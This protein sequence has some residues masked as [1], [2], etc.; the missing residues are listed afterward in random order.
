MPDVA[1]LHHNLGTCSAGWRSSSKPSPHTSRHCGSIP[2]SPFRTLIWG[3]YCGAKGR[4]AHALP[5]MKQAVEFEPA[6]ADFWQNLA[7]LHVEM[8]NSAECLTCWQ[9]VVAL[10][11]KRTYARL[12]LGWALQEEGD[13]QGAIEQ[14]HTAVQLQPDSGLAELNIGSWHEEQGQLAEAEAAYR[15][16]LELQPNFRHPARPNSHVRLRGKLSD[17]DLAAPEIASPT[18]TLAK[19]PRARLRRA[20]GMFWTHAA[21]LLG[22]ADCLR[23]ANATTLEMDRDR[24]GYSPDDHEQFIERLVDAF[25]AEYFRRLLAPA[26]IV[27]VRCLSSDFPAR[28]RPSSSRSWPVTRASM[29]QVNCVPSARAS[30]NC[31]QRCARIGRS[32]ASRICTQTLPILAKQHLDRLAAIERTRS[33]SSTRCPIITCTRISIHTVSGADFIHVGA[34]LAQRRGLV[35]DD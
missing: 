27:R 23:Q 8:E 20:C 19:G 25:D 34:R 7:E 10:D 11:D 1:A 9:R 21:I 26:L 17:E 13:F 4:W 31:R 6:N 12:A 18:R 15:K 33:E 2:I 22:P 28:G 30:N 29:G 5:W 35:L 32:I 3:W 24:H 16:A 14:Y